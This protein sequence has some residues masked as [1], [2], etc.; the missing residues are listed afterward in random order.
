MFGQGL[1]ATRAALRS[2][3]S[4][5]V[6][7]SRRNYGLPKILRVANEIVFFMAAVRW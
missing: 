7:R 6:S 1:L 2:D 4:A 5:D 3:P